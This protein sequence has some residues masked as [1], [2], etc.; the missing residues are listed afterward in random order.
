MNCLLST[1]YSCCSLKEFFVLNPPGRELYLRSMKR[2]WEGRKP[3]TGDLVAVKFGVREAVGDGV[4]DG[5]KLFKLRIEVGGGCTVKVTVRNGDGRCKGPSAVSSGHGAE[6]GITWQIGT[7]NRS[8]GRKRPPAKDDTSAFG[9]MTVTGI[10]NV[11]KPP[12]AGLP[13]T[14]L[15]GGGWLLSR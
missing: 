11:K 3:R 12:I 8:Q 4:A 1:L 2:S 9:P 5:G 10:K 7:G 15:P 14:P 13:N 6:G